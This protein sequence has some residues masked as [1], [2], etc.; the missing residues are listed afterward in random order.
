MP[1]ISKRQQFQALMAVLAIVEERRSVSI[2]DASA[3]VGV[4]VDQ[5]RP[6][7]NHVLYLEFRDNNDE[8]ISKT[9][10]FLLDEHDELVMTDQHWLRN[11][12]AIPPSPSVALRLLVAC[13]VMRSL[14]DTAQ[15]PLDTAIAKLERL[16]AADVVVPVDRPPMLDIC[17]HARSLRR[18]LRIRYLKDALSEVTDREIAPWSV[19]SNWGKWYAYGPDFGDDIAKSFRVDRILTAELGEHEFDAPDI[20]T[21]FPELFN[22]EEYART[23]RVRIDPGAL[24]GLPNPLRLGPRIDIG[25]GRVEVDLTVFSDQRLE[26]LLLMLP[27]GTDILDAPEYANSRRAAAAELLE[28]YSA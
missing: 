14:D 4:A 28:L 21:E 25:D 12:A 10:A 7:L 24:D 6:L 16:V 11:L 15:R 9:A 22:L 13:T 2:V 8:L 3:E 20:V 1:P 26:N 23:V 18:T 5:L 17:E 27:V 19:Y